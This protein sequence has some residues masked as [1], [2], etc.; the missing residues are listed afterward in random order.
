MT[1]VADLITSVQEGIGEVAGPGVQVF[2][3]D[4]IHKAIQRTFNILWL[5]YPWE[6]YRV[7]NQLALDE[8]A[9][10][11]TSATALATMQAFHDLVTVRRPSSDVV[12]TP[13]PTKL[14]P[15]VL[16]GTTVQHYTSL[17]VTD[18]DYATKRLQFWPLASVGTVDIC[19]KVYPDDIE[20]TEQELYLDEDLIA[21]GAMMQMLATEDLSQQGY[22]LAR[23]LFDLRF[24]DIMSALGQH[25]IGTV[26]RSDQR[27]LTQWS[28]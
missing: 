5:K 17:P 15:Y 13:L 10:K 19:H 2:S 28:T 24:T 4:R 12:I 1:T 25:E 23:E 18:A 16:T 3:E 8:T 20:D 6:Q 27:Y 14:N 21:Y 22:A 9:G 26:P 11:V 7:W